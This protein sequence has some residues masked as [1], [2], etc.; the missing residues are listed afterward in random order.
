MVGHRNR[1]VRLCSLVTWGWCLLFRKHRNGKSVAGPRPVCSS[2]TCGFPARS[3]Q[4]WNCTDSRCV[5][6]FCRTLREPGRES[7]RRLTNVLLP[8]GQTP[9]LSMSPVINRVVW[10]ELVQIVF[11]I[12]SHHWTIHIFLLVYVVTSYGF[13][14]VR[15]KTPRHFKPWN[16][17][18]WMQ[19]NWTVGKSHSV[20]AAQRRQVRLSSQLLWNTK[21]KTIQQWCGTER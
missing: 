16:N 10:N 4:A 19:D 18:I 17:R 20:V 21:D 1:A 14:R 3:S 7:F 12:T 9:Q 6:F 5:Q 13:R 15:R 11:E 8:I 2:D